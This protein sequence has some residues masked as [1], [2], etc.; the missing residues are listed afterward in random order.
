MAQELRAY[1]PTWREIIGG[2]ISGDSK[3]YSPR[4]AMARA[5]TGSSGLGGGVG[6]LDLLPV[7]GATVGAQ[8]AIHDGDYKGAALSVLPL[9]AAARVGGRALKTAEKLESK[10]LSLHNPPVKTPRPFEADYPAGAMT[11]DA[12]RLTADIEGRP[13][14][15]DYIAGRRMVGGGDVSLTP[16]EIRS[17]GEKGTGRDIAKAPPSEIRGAVGAVAVK[18]G[19]RAPDQIFF[20]D[21]LTEAQAGRVIPH[22][23]G[24]VVDQLA[25]EIPTEGLSREL[26][27]VYNTLNTGRERTTNLMGPKHVGYKGDEIGREYM[28]EAVRGYMLDPNYL[29][30]VAPKTAARIR[31]YVNGNPALNKTIQF[32]SLAGVGLLGA[33]V[34]GAPDESKAS[35]V[36]SII[37]VESGG[38]PNARNPRS[39]A[40]GLGQFIDSTWVSMIQKHRPDLA[41]GKSRDELIALKSDPDLSREMTAAYA[42]DN[43]QILAGAGLPVT[44]GTTYLAHFA[45]PQGAVKVLQADPAAPVSSVLGEAAVKANPF[46]QG[47][48][49]GGLQSWADKK[50]GGQ[51]AA[52]QPA[53]VQA[54]PQPAP[55]QQPAMTMQA[56]A[57]SPYFAQAAPQQAQA[58]ASGDYW[59]Q[60]AAD[61]AT[62]GPP[63]I[64]PRRKQVNLA[65]LRAAFPQRPFFF[66]KL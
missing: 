33:G 35:T 59:S 41:Q 28:A 64:P 51:A 58:K 22:E 18:P 42:A 38:N 43:G 62:Q 6:L 13:L 54:A 57:A 27:Q 52:P 8:E 12:G 20:S 9:G 47:M 21:K 30:T 37:G 31:E 2:W 7:A 60:I 5:L 15:A 44:P 49:V 25:S 66:G 14:T 40:S 11:D 23:V 16:S 32:N 26:S 65:S 39:S 10:T 24:H 29:K 19:S 56:P 45:G 53:P 1:N 63:I 36:D 50:M 34:L 4:A 48:T 61:D 17:V 55:V 3:S 46:L